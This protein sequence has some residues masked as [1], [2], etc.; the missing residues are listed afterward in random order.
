MRK[1]SD[2]YVARSAVVVGNVSIGPLASIWYNAVV[3]GDV[4]PIRIGA[5]VNI[6]DGAIVHC[7][8]D[9]PLEIADDVTIA[10]QAVVHCT[11]VGPRSLIGIGATLLD[12]VEIGAD[13][14][15]A[16]RSLVVPGTI[17]PDG[18]FVIGSP[19]RVTRPSSDRDRAYIALAARTYLDLA[20]RHAAAE[21]R[22]RAR[23]PAGFS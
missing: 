3:R 10:H 12:D 2:Y 6:Q 5:R 4:A 9:V 1:V 7:K 13:C 18:S 22:D 17:V 8:S 16:A 19:A 14:F 11:R 15:V 21:F 23:P 20:P